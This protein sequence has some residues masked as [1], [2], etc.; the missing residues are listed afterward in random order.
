MANVD[1]IC[2]SDIRQSR[3]IGDSFSIINLTINLTIPLQN[4]LLLTQSIHAL[5]H[6]IRNQVHPR[7]RKFLSDLDRALLH[8]R[9]L[10]QKF[11]GCLERYNRQQQP[12]KGG[13][14]PGVDTKAED[15]LQVQ[16]TVTSLDPVEDL[17]C[18]LRT[19]EHDDSIDFVTELNLYNADTVEVVD[20]V[21]EWLDKKDI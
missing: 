21:K 19:A 15:G 12:Q 9:E 17:L 13:G 4:S 7:E 6:E 1:S 3:E 8:Y 18:V 16:D 2:A 14:R 10:W 11:T 5:H 20:K